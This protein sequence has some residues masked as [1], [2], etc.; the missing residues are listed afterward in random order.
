M[1]LTDEPSADCD[2]LVSTS[3]PPATNISSFQFESPPVQDVFRHS[4]ESSGSRFCSFSVTTR[5]FSKDFIHWD[6]WMFTS[7]RPIIPLSF[8]CDEEHTCRRLANWDQSGPSSD[9]KLVLFWKVRSISIIHKQSVVCVN[10]SSTINWIIISVVPTQVRGFKPG[11]SRPIFQGEKN[12]STPSLGREVRPF[13]PCR[14]FTARKRSLNIM[15]KSGIF[16]QNSSV[17]S[18]PRSSSFHN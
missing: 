14:R 13:V 17:I 10:S 4:N 18:R 7:Y 5:L 1:L 6:L 11:R 9:T 3:G 16:G 8:K 12:L 15:W 2:S